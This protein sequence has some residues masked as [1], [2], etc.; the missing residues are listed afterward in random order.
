[1]LRD[2]LQRYVFMLRGL[3]DS[4]MLKMCPQFG[5][6]G[7]VPRKML[8]THVQILHYVSKYKYLFM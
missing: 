7:A 5:Y 3:M 6:A 1:M 8:R 2:V 4:S